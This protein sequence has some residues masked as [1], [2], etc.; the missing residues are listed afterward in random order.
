MMAKFDVPLG[1]VQY[2][3]LVER[4]ATLAGIAARQPEPDVSYLSALYDVAQLHGLAPHLAAR[5][6]APGGV[7]VEAPPV[8][9][10]GE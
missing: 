1:M 7:S 10:L 2:D 9:R 4:L 6:E 5:L 8:L 3:E